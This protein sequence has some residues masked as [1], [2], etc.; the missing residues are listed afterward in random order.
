MATYQNS[1]LKKK[2]NTKCWQACWETASHICC[3]GDIRWYS[4]SGNVWQFLIKLTCYHMIQQLLSQ[5]FIQ[6]KWKPIFM[7]KTLHFTMSITILFLRAKIGSIPSVIQQPMVK[8]W[9][10]PAVENPMAMKKN[11][12]LIHTTTRMVHRGVVLRGKAGHKR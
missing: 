2:V 7:G 10:I 5:D 8:Q 9:Y 6:E 3:F 4:C 12:V 1:S 11:Q